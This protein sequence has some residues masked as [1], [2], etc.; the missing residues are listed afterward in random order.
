MR[1]NMSKPKSVTEKVE[2]RL[3]DFVKDCRAGALLDLYET[4]FGED[5][6]TD[7]L[8]KE[9]NEHEDGEQRSD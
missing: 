6:L 2:E 9:I 3:I 5:E 8:R 7:E 4:V 1:S